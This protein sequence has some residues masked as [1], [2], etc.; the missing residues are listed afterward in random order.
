MLKAKI[1]GL[2]SRPNQ[3]VTGK[4]LAV[5]EPSGNLI[6]IFVTIAPGVCRPYFVGDN[7]EEFNKVA[8]S[9]GIV[10]KSTVQISEY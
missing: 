9:L 10:T 8:S 4:Q 3:E 1:V 7:P 2:D 5:Y 6:A